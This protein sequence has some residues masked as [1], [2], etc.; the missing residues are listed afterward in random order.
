MFLSNE[1][2]QGYQD[3][4][5]LL[6]NG[7]F[8]PAR[9]RFEKALGQEPDNVEILIRIAQCLLLEQDEDSAAERLK[10]A[11]KLNPFEPEIRLWL[12]RAMHRRGEL[13]KAIAELRVAH[14]EL[15]GSELAPTWYAEA[16]LASGQRASAIS[17]LEKD[18]QEYPFHGLLSLPVPEVSVFLGVHIAETED[19]S[20][21]GGP[22]GAVNGAIEL[23][24]YRGEHIAIAGAVD[25]YL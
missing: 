8:R 13:R 22:Q 5:N 23:R 21:V 9:D 4:V 7:K 6:N 12:G 2:F 24:A 18:V 25:R 11:R 15:K 16:L 20:Q 3:G 10:L 19:H 14:Q 1:S 17:V